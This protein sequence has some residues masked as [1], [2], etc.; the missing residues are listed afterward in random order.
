MK[1]ATGDSAMAASALGSSLT[2][3]TLTKRSGIAF[4]RRRNSARIVLAAEVHPSLR[5]GTAWAVESSVGFPCF[6]HSGAMLNRN[7]SNVVIPGGLRRHRRPNP[8]STFP[9]CAGD[10]WMKGSAHGPCGQTRKATIVSKGWLLIVL[11]HWVAWI[12]RGD[13]A[14]SAGG[15]HASERIAA[16]AGHDQL[17]RLCKPRTRRRGSRGACRARTTCEH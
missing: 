8:E 13:R 17:L 2:D 14:R 16:G 7:V 11:D 12:V 5:E 3:A 15:R 6:R 1:R 9:L 4:V 10:Y